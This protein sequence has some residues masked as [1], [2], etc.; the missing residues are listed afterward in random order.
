MAE[1]THDAEAPSAMSAASTVSMT[2]AMSGAAEAAR[3]TAVSWDR[4]SFASRWAFIRRMARQWSQRR[5]SGER[6]SRSM[7]QLF[8]AS[9]WTV[10]ST[11]KR[12]A[13]TTMGR[14]KSWSSVTI[15]RTMAMTA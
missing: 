5:S 9:F 6:R 15:I 4:A 3:T 8:G 13:H 12:W 14:H 10:S 11:L 2:R 7:T 1:E